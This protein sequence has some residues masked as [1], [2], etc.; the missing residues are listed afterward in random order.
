[1]DEYRDAELVADHGCRDGCGCDV[2]ENRHDEVLMRRDGRK[3]R[4]IQRFLKE[5]IDDGAYG[6]RYE[7]QGGDGRAG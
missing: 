4:K 1:M 6:F 7:I 5:L 3:H 2:I